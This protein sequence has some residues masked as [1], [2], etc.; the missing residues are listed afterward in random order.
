[1]ANLL[2]DLWQSGEPNWTAALATSPSIKVHLYG[3]KTPRLGRKMGHLTALADT[4][5]EALRQ[6]VDARKAL[7]SSR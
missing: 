6:V 3:K 4:P 1:M 7:D 2:G 5:A